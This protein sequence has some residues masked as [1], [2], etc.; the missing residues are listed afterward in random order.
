MRYPG[1]EKLEIIRVVEQSPLPAR[2]TLS[3]LGIPR[4]TFYRW[5]DRYSRG[6][7]E[8][9]KRSAA[10]S[11]AAFMTSRTSRTR[12]G[13]IVSGDELETKGLIRR[14]ADPDDRRAHR[15]RLTQRGQSLRD[16]L[17]SPV[18]AAQARILAPL[19]SHERQLL[20]DLLTRVVEAN[21]EYAR[22]GA[23]RR[24]PRKTHRPE[25]R[26][27]GAKASVAESGR[28]PAAMDRAEAANPEEG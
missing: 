17:I 4:A 8:A 16:R 15:L 12:Y 11:Q 5:Y 22:P 28:V 27:R 20:V 7:P 19:A 26:S 23:G 1:T 14:L 13:A 6:G 18:I 2:Q 3:K 9:F 10:P 24:P 25:K 21:E